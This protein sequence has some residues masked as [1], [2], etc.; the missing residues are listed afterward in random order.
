VVVNLQAVLYFD[1]RRGIFVIFQI[2]EEVAR[3]FDRN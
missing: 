3:L 2:K 1:V